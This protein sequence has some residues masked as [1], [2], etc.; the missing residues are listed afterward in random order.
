MGILFRA[1]GK[2]LATAI[3]ALGIFILSF[4]FWPK[5][6][7]WLQDGAAWF[8]DTVRTPG[9]L[10]EKAT[11]LYRTFVN[12]STVL[13]IL[14]TAIAR[15]VVEIVAFVFGRVGVGR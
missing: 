4:M 1:S 11:V 14:V 13:G 6:I 5:G 10:D 3:V 15:L 7:L 12:D 9:F 2:L 8:V